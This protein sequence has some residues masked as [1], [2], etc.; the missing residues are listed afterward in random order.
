MSVVGNIVKRLG[1]LGLVLSGAGQTAGAGS[2][3][4]VLEVSRL[5]VSDQ[6]LTDG[7]SPPTYANLT[8]EDGLRDGAPVGITVMRDVLAT[9]STRS[10][11]AT[12]TDIPVRYLDVAPPIATRGS[13]LVTR[14]LAAI[15]SGTGQCFWGSWLPSPGDCTMAMRWTPGGVNGHAIEHTSGLDGLIIRTQ[16]AGQ[17][18]YFRSVSAGVQSGN[19]GGMAVNT[20]TS[21]VE[22]WVFVSYTQST[23][24]YTFRVRLASDGSAVYAGSGT[25][26]SG[27]DMSTIHRI[28]SGAAQNPNGDIARIVV[29]DSAISTTAMDALATSDDST[30]AVRDYATCRTGCFDAAAPTTLFYSTGSGGSVRATSGS[31]PGDA[32]LVSLGGQSNALGGSSSGTTVD[33]INRYPV[34]RYVYPQDNEAHALDDHD[35][36]PGL[37]GWLLDSITEPDDP[38]RVIHCDGAAGTG[39]AS[40]LTATTGYADRQIADLVARGWTPKAHIF[41][42][43][44]ADATAGSAPTYQ[45]QLE[46]YIAR[47]RAT[48]PGLPVII[49]EIAVAQTTGGSYDEADS[50]RSSQATVAAADAD[51][52]LISRGSDTALHSTN[53]TMAARAALV[54]TLL[55]STL[56]V[57]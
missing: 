56:G 27:L 18:V 50:I 53:T 22:Y 25:T 33:P 30:G 44:E 4:V 48:F 12:S 43:G 2:P 24:A 54:E 17:R 26:T 19:L 49:M 52:Y 42:Q 29:W 9:E 31:H 46:T 41:W 7:T 47:W 45:S 37:E 20:L 36:N 8:V 16:F 40:H 39:I 38:Q 34:G 35:A 51:A 5:S 28:G 15:D 57:W 32:K 10:T 1:V 21:G 55:V 6:S 11:V 13:K 3:P 23:G 14:T